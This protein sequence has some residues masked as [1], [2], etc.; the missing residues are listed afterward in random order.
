MALGDVDISPSETRGEDTTRM[1]AGSSHL[2]SQARGEAQLPPFGLEN[3]CCNTSSYAWGD[4][5]RV[6]IS[7]VGC[8]WLLLPTS[9][10]PTTAWE[11][12]VIVP[13]S[14]ALDAGTSLPGEGPSGQGGQ[15]AKKDQSARGYIDTT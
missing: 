13:A 1:E 6:Y 7:T 4:G 12:H 15:G 8:S 9:N 5:S 11:H 2:S 10:R 14:S 3:A